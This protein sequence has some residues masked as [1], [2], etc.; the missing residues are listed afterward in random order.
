MARPRLL[1]HWMTVI[2]R[3]LA[4]NLL[5]CPRKSSAMSQFT[6]LNKDSQDC[7]AEMM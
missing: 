7:S 2:I 1:N 3:N 4:M 5:S 6:H